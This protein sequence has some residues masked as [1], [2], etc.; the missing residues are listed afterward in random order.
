MRV[1]PLLTY[2]V[3]RLAAFVVPFSLML[4]I[5]VFREQVWLAALFAAL[6][7]LSISII[8]LRKPLTDISAQMVAKRNARLDEEAEDAAIDNDEAR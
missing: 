5:P 6:I 8:F 4:L 1:P 7:G 3:L 2:T